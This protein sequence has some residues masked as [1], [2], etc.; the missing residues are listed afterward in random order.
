MSE[1][2]AAPAPEITCT[3][4]NCD[5]T[6]TVLKEATGHAWNTEHALTAVGTEGTTFTI[7]VHDGSDDE[8]EDDDYLGEDGDL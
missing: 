5:F 8:D 6:T 7:S 2:P 3:E 4:E 1:T